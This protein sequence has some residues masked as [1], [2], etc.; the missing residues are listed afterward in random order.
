MKWKF[1][2]DKGGLDNVGFKDN[3]I[4]KFGQ[5]P[6]KS[7]VREAIQNSCD[8]LDI[9]NGKTQVNVVIC[10]GK[11]AK[12]DLPE[13]KK[14]EEHIRACMDPE[15]DDAENAEVKRHIEAFE[16]ES[17]TYLEISDYNTTGMDYKSFKSLTQAIFKSD[18]G[19][20]GSQ[21]SKGVGKAAYYASSYLRTMLIATRSDDGLRYRGA[22][23]LASHKCPFTNQ[24]LNY[25]GLY[26]D[27]ELKDDKDVPELFRRSEKGTSIF[28]TGLWDLHNL[29]QDII[30]EVLRN[31]WFAILMDQLTVKLNTI[32]INKANVGNYIESYFRDYRDYKTGEKQNPRPYYDTVLKG[33]EYKRHI[34]NIGECSLWL[35]QNIEYNLGAVARF[36]K[37]KMLIYKEKNLDVGYSGVFLCDNDE[38][39][40]FLK[41]I[42]NDAHDSWNPKIN[43]NYTEKATE[44]LRGIKEFIKD[45]YAEFAG[46]NDQDAFNVDTLDELFNF[47]GSNSLNRSKP[48]QPKPK[49]SPDSGEKKD[50]ILSHA[51]FLAYRKNG[52]LLYRL[53]LVSNYSK[54]DQ[55][56]KISIGTDS[57]KDYITILNSSQGNYNGNELVIDVKKGKN[58][59]DS[60]ELDASYIVAPTITSINK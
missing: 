15:N 14:I 58:I 43:A 6:A 5:D 23:K 28:V 35:D 25:K 52:K 10:K 51:N 2:E 59:I 40:G 1:A 27:L 30:Q 37:T 24:D 8:A 36:R 42:E 7:I 20:S 3:D 50:R 41:E 47:S 13:F 46:I 32:E 26:G 18:K 48:P 29:D 21:G 45:K 44:T 57:S 22:A 49:P 9:T 54:R 12:S 38:G 4:E 16:Q 56:F 53:E 11:I 60:I 17:Y 31:Y 39:N 34:A 55:K 19:Y 33:K